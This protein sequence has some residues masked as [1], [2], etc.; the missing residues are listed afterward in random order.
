VDLLAHWDGVAVWVSF[1]THQALRVSRRA[2]GPCT[3]AGS[4]WLEIALR[5]T[6]IQMEAIGVGEW[7][8]SPS[9]SRM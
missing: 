6:V 3:G 5:D 9:G 4:K 1:E 8:R 2:Y 7:M